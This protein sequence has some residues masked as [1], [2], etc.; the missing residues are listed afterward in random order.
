[1]GHEKIFSLA[2]QSKYPIPELLHG[3]CF[4]EAYFQGRGGVLT[5]IPKGCNY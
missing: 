1:M 2:L 5:R 3:D 4:Q